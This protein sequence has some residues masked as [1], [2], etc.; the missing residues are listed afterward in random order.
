[1]GFINDFFDGDKID[2]GTFIYAA[3]RMLGNVTDDSSVA[4]KVV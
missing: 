1:M 2:V 4:W 3:K